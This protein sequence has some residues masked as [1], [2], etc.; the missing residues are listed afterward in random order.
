MSIGGA[1]SSTYGTTVVL[2]GAFSRGYQLSTSAAPVVPPTGVISFYDGGS[3]SGTLLGTAVPV[4]QP[5]GYALYE[6][7]LPLATL[8]VGT[9]NIVAYYPGDTNYG[10][11]VS[12]AKPLT[13]GQGTPRVTVSPATVTYGTA[14]AALSATVSFTGGSAPTG[15]VVFTVD[16]G[17]GVSAACTATTT[18]RTCTAVYPVAS[19]AGGTHTVNAIEAA[20]STYLGAAGTGTLTINPNPNGSISLVTTSVLTPQAGGALVTI[21]VANVGTGL[22]QNVTL[23]GVIVGAGS[24]TPLPQSLGNVQPGASATTT[25]AVSSVAG[26][27]GSTVVEK[28]TGSYTGGSFGGSYRVRLP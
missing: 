3:I 18:T 11:S 10:A 19:L 4:F 22:A 6:A 9:H 2:D 14:T 25:V 12:A 26:A 20:D 24:G 13:V 16:G 21:T 28:I 23:T 5:G 27:S 1:N 7:T 8:P 17:T 15:A